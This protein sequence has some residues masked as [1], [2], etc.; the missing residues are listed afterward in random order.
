MLPTWT[1]A[2]SHISPAEAKGTPAQSFIETQVRNDNCLPALWPERHRP[3]MSKGPRGKPEH[4]QAGYGPRGVEVGGAEL[5]RAWVFFSIPKSLQPT[6]PFWVCS[7]WAWHRWLWAPQSNDEAEEG[8]HEGQV[9]ALEGDLAAWG[10]GRGIECLLALSQWDIKLS[11]RIC[12]LA[13]RVGSARTANGTGGEMGAMQ[14]SGWPFWETP[15]VVS[16]GDAE[17]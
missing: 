1:R 16:R 4:T 17:A 15:H 13:R 11:R 6:P 3:S 12:C 10:R 8:S 14:G 9:R 2:V 5:C 7:P